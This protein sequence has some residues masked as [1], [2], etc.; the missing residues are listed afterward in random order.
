MRIIV[1]MKM[2][3]NPEKP[4]YDKN[5]FRILRDPAES[6][7]NFDDGNALEMALKIRDKGIEGEAV[8]IIVLAMG[9]KMSEKILE[10]AYALGVDEAYLV[11][12]DRLVRADTLLTAK[13]L[14]AAVR[15]IGNYDVVLAGFKSQDGKTGSIGPMIAEYLNIP[16]LTYVNSFYKDENKIIA[17]VDWED[18]EEITTVPIPCL[19][20]NNQ[21]KY[22]LRRMTLRGI[23]RSLKMEITRWKLDD[24]ENNQ[25]WDFT[26]KTKVVEVLETHKSRKHKKLQLAKEEENQNEP[27]IDL[28][29]MV[30]EIRTNLSKLI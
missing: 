24:L 10:E 5:S 30:R 29:E 14:S 26:P 15:K 20:V 19:L 3:Q 18:Y 27:A 21:K 6:I 16:I 13:C 12:D 22:E 9:P 25:K 8:Q 28:K 23:Q 7:I 2:V 17:S 1:L 4:G 11:E